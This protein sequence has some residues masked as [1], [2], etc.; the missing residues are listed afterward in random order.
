VGTAADGQYHA[1]VELLTT[2]SV[3]AA[4]ATWYS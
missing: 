3:L 2:K 1:A 4:G